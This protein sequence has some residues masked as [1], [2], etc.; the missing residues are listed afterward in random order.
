[1]SLLKNEISA[2]TPP[3][4]APMTMAANSTTTIILDSLVLNHRSA[5]GVI[6][7]TSW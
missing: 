1:M 2:N 7:T 3:A 5:S 6:E 4:I